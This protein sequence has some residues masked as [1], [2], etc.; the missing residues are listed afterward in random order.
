MGDSGEYESWTSMAKKQKLHAQGHLQREQDLI[1]EAPFSYLARY[2]LEEF[3]FGGL[4]AAQVQKL[5]MMAKQDG[6]KHTFVDKLARLVTH[7]KHHS[8]IHRDLMVYM[9]KYLKPYSKPEADCV[10]IPLK[11]L[12]GEKT[13][14]HLIPHYYLA[15]HKLMSYMYHTYKTSFQDTILGKEGAMEEFWN[16]IAGGDPR[17]IQ[18]AS[19]HPEYKKKCVPIIIHGGGVPCTNSHSLDTISFESLLAKRGLGSNCSTLDYIFFITGVFTQTMESEDSL[20]SGKTKTE[21][22]KF[23]VHSL[24]ACY[25]GKWPEQDPLGKDF[26]AR[27]MNHKHRGHEIMGGYV[28][29]PW[30]IKGDMDFQINHFEIPGHWNNPHPCP[31]CPCNKVQ[32]SPM[33]WNNFDPEAEW[34]T[35]GFDSLEAFCE[36]CNM[37]GKPIHQLFHTLE[38]GGLG[39]HPKSLYMDCLHVVDLGIAMHVCGNVLF[40]LC[41]DDM[42]PHTAAANM[43]YLWK[44]IDKLYHE[45]DVTSQFP[46]LGLANF[47]NPVSPHA[48]F[49]KLKGKG[50]QIRHL[51]PLLAVI[52]KE[53]MRDGN[54]QRHDRL[55]E[56]VL[57]SLDCF[58][59]LLDYTN[60]K[61][62]YPFR[63]P[64]HIAKHMLKHA[65]IFLHCYMVLAD[66]SLKCRP[67]KFQWNL[68]LK[69]HYFWHLAQSAMDLNPR[70]AWCYA[71]EDFVGKI[72]IIGMSC[73][74]G[75]VAASRSQSLVSKYI[76][77]IVLRMFHAIAS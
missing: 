28:L 16:T 48:D 59:N 71:N 4:S 34:K 43:D 66:Q 54:R 36:H 8:N 40:L 68:A 27:S 60:G 1:C 6:I 25:Y 75:Q 38:Q 31:A 10:K 44:E 24:R 42:L 18:L 12:K 33:A 23:I 72:A 55:V 64:E 7:G 69:H 46:H 52:W 62:I 73:R 3:A 47:C 15:P 74:H 56:K 61:G 13:G 76:L 32:G 19:D 20:G 39:M 14:T 2:L 50:A 63:S 65:D 77:G 67:A 58:Y 29:V 49:P 17:L 5:A 57:D 22:W 30:I 70:M 45:F 41:Y 21:M 53:H 26:P 51:V 9:P 35:K 37:L 11:I